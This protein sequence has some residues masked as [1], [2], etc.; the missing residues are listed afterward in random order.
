M[1]LEK[2]FKDRKISFIHNR[3]L[4][5]IEY[6]CVHGIKCLS[7][8]R[9]RYIFLYTLYPLCL[10]EILVTYKSLVSEVIPNRNNLCIG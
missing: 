7:S 2:H 3:Y 8:I 6:Y 9:L 4:V 5:Q 1:K 10:L